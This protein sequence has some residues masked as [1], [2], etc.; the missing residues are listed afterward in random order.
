MDFTELKNNGLL[1]NRQASMAGIF[2]I[3]V[4]DGWM[5]SC[6]G[7]MNNYCAAI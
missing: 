3:S 2:H 6:H 5:N 1:R 4:A 7:I